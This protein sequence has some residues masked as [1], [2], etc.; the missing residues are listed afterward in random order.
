GAPG[1]RAHSRRAGARPGCGNPRRRHGDRR[2]HARSPR[3]RRRRRRAADLAVDE[4]APPHPGGL[5]L[6]HD[7]ASPRRKDEAPTHVRVHARA[8]VAT[9]RSAARTRA[10][11]RRAMTPIART[12]HAPGLFLALAPMDGITDGVYRELLTDLFDGERDRK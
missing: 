10:R 5:H 2:R 9:P 3:V 7:A 1:R 11:T 12:P 8:V 6:P 4:R